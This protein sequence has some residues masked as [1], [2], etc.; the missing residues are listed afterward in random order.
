MKTR[1]FFDKTLKNDKETIKDLKEI[2][3]NMYLKYIIQKVKKS[4]ELK[5]KRIN[6]FSIYFNNFIVSEQGCDKQD[7]TIVAKM[8]KMTNYLSLHVLKVG[9][10]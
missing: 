1:L 10:W 2:V 7:Y 6:A 4:K 5:R 9:E 3:E 8:N